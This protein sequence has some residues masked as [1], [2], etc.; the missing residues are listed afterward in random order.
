MDIQAIKKAIDIGT[1]SGRIMAQVVVSSY[2]NGEMINLY[3]LDHLDSRNFGLAIQIMSFRRTP[4]W[5]DEEFWN[6]ERYA[7]RR[8]GR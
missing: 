5:S 8:L 2:R 6:L 3:D 7:V 4:G 1:E